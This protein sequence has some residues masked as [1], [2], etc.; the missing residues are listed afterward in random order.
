ML[1]YRQIQ[2]IAALLCWTLREVEESLEMLNAGFMTPDI[3]DFMEDDPE[4]EGNGAGYYHRLSAA[5]YLDC[6]EWSGP[7]PS[8]EDA[9]AD[10]L[11][12]Y[13]D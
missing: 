11:L 10:L 2:D 3:Q 6:T 5:G 9:V 4:T 13:A 1:T 7:F 8:E 12:T